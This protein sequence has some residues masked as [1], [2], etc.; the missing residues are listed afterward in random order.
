[1]I[2]CSSRLSSLLGDQSMRPLV[3]FLFGMLMLLLVEARARAGMPAPLPTEADNVYRKVLKLD[4]SAVERLQ[5]ISFFLLGFLLCAAVVRW[6]WNIVQRDAPQLP[7]LSFG[8]ALAGVLLW[9]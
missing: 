8:K 4:G 1:M 5:A 2:V 9:G 6:L 3:L 7:R